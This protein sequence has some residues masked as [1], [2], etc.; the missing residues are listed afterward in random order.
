MDLLVDSRKQGDP[1]WTFY[2]GQ[3]AKP[4]TLISDQPPVVI[5]DLGERAVWV[6]DAH[7]SSLLIR[8][9]GIIV[10]IQISDRS[11]KRPAIT[12]AQIE[13]LGKEVASHL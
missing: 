5:G 10:R 4:S 8:R 13:I 9:H 1:Q 12:R 6:P 11:L 7:A 2:D 3:L